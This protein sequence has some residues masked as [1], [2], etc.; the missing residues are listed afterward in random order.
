[1]FKKLICSCG[2]EMEKR[3][4]LRKAS[5]YKVLCNHCGR[6]HYCQPGEPEQD[7]YDRIR[8]YISGL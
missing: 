8:E 6:E 5:T 2:E 4:D 3:Y 1:M 7:F